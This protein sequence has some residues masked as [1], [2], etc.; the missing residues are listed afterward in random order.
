MYYV[1]K[2]AGKQNQFHRSVIKTLLPKEQTCGRSK[3][4]RL[5]YRFLLL[6]ENG[7]LYYELK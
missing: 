2:F 1:K 3:H 6:A 7:K 4:V 5:D